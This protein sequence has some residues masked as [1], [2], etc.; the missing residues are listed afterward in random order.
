MEYFGTELKILNETFQG[1]TVYARSNI[2]DAT[3]NALVVAGEDYY[4]RLKVQ[5]S[6]N[7]LTNVVLYDSI[8]RYLKVGDSINPVDGDAS[9][10][11]GTFKGI[12]V[13]NANNFSYKY[14]GTNY[15]VVVKTYYSWDTKL[16]GYEKLD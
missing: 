14:N 2:S 5:T 6:E 8:E 1:Y 4:Y 15:K 12:N 10:Y 9:S 11:H 16:D 3:K 13:T 7:K